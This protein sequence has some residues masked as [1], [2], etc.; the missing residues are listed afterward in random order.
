MTARRSGHG[1]EK[2]YA[3]AELWVERA[4]RADDSLFTPGSEIWSRGWLE[5]LHRKYLDQEA[6]VHGPFTA[7][8]Q[9]LL[10]GSSPQAQ[11]LMAEI[12][13]VH[14]LILWT[15][16]MRQDR[17]RETVDTVLSWSNPQISIPNDLVEGLAPGIANLNPG[18]S[19]YRAYL[20]GFIIEF[21]EQWKEQPRRDIDRCLADPWA[22]KDFMLRLEFRSDYLRNQQN[23]VNLQRHALLHLVFPDTFEGM[24]SNHKSRLLHQLGHLAHG[25]ADDEDMQLVEVRQNLEATYGDGF[26]YYDEPVR[27]LWLTGST[28]G[29]WGAFIDRARA[30]VDTGRLEEDELNYKLE[31]AEKLAAVREAVLV[32]KDGWASDVMDAQ[33]NRGGQHGRGNLLNW[34]ALQSLEQWFEESPDDALKALQGIWTKDDVTIGQRIRGFTER[35]PHP[36][37][38]RGAGVRARNGAAFLMAIDVEQYPPFMTSL[39]NDGYERTAY[40]KPEREADAASLYEHA[41]GFLDR[42]IEEAS[43]RGLE[44]RHRLDAQ[45]VMWGVLGGPDEDEGDTEQDS[46]EATVTKSL[47]QVAEECF[48]PVGFLQEIVKL[49]DDKKQVIFQG[50][51]G[52]GKTWVAQRLAEHLAGGDAKR[53]RV[54][55]FHPSYAYEDFVQG[56]RPKLSGGQAG[57]ELRNG[58]LVRIAKDAEEDPDNNYYLIIDEIN[59]G[60]LAKVFGELYFLLEYRGTEMRLQYSDEP[61]RMPGNLYII[62]TMNTADRS[63]AL[64][65]LALRRRFHFMEF[66][67]DEWPVKDV[68]RKWIAANA[69]EMD[70]V[71]DVVDRANRLLSDED[72]AIGPSYFMKLGLDEGMVQLVWEHNVKPYIRERLHGQRDRM[73]EFD[74]KRLRGHGAEEGDEIEDV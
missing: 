21:A 68:L 44:L 52:T 74:L 58:P 36:K 48:L 33:R 55:Q 64:V 11:Q 35:L 10:V 63:I 56:F 20:V 70:W 5:E 53:V 69:P 39:F 60:N 30:Y 16:A 25:A 31:I 66:R 57:F 29:P 42:F 9:Q 38:A 43:E 17:K 12:L 8:L 3:A 37:F 41:L 72:A 14:L 27:S 54:V 4:L 19:T 7:T 49:L 24:S 59:R 46:D 40:A 51:P 1:E 71:A 45:S 28:P 2:V 47:A 32:A 50:P 61:F 26:G 67:A 23:L 13:Y 22:F 65:D 34:R 18:F 15:G 62:G 6:E 73:G